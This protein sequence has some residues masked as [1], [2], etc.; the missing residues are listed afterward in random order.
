M[1]NK[2]V[3]KKSGYFSENRENRQGKIGGSTSGVYGKL[4][5]R[6]CI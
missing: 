4:S 3:K 2:N 1:I 5:E 6:G